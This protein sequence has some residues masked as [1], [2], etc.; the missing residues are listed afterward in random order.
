MS[1]G[2]Q[3]D[4]TRMD[5][6]YTAREA[7]AESDRPAPE[8]DPD[9]VRDARQTSSNQRRT[10]PVPPSPASPPPDFI[11]GGDHRDPD[12]A[13]VT[14]PGLEGAARTPAGE[15]P[16]PMQSDAAVVEPAVPSPGD[17]NDEHGHVAVS[18]KAALGTS[19]GLPAVE[20][21]KTT[22]L[23]QPGKPDGEVAT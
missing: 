17:V 13:N 16:T 5:S 15:Q 18:T 23:A 4:N 19:E 21:I 3:F 8:T 7:D 14:E 6:P 1:D 9:E 12:R 2:T 22:S 20:G 11:E 10:E